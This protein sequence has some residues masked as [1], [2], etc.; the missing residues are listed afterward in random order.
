M[1]NSKD[2]EREEVSGVVNRSGGRDGFPTIM[3]KGGRVDL[4]A[5][6]ACC[7]L[8]YHHP[9]GRSDGYIKYPFITKVLYL[10]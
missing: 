7:L 10:S 6:S 4:S 9:Y 1:P 3:R 5:M 2:W 8:A